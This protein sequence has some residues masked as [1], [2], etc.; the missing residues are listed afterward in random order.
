MAFITNRPKRKNTPQRHRRF[1]PVT[2]LP[3]VMLMLGLMVMSP[4]IEAW[5]ANDPFTPPCQLEQDRLFATG[6]PIQ[7]ASI[8]QGQYDPIDDA[9]SIRQ[10][11]WSPDGTLL[12]AR[13]PNSNE[14]NEAVLMT[15]DGEVRHVFDEDV[16]S[17][18]LWSDDSQSIEFSGGLASYHINTETWETESWVVPR[19]GF[20]LFYNNKSKSPNGRYAPYAIQHQDGTVSWY[21][22][23]L[24]DDAERSLWS[25]GISVSDSR[26]VGWSANS[27]FLYLAVGQILMQYDIGSHQLRDV[28]ELPYVPGGVAISPDNTKIMIYNTEHSAVLIAINT[29]DMTTF[30]NNTSGY[31]LGWTADSRYWVYGELRNKS[32]YD[33][34]HVYDTVENSSRRLNIPAGIDRFKIELSPSGRYLKYLSTTATESLLPSNYAVYDLET[35]S[36]HAI[37]AYSFNHRLQLFTHEGKDYLLIQKQ[38]SADQSQPYL[39]TL[40]DAENLSVCKIGYTSWTVEFQPQG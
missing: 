18:P 1:L 2:I 3:I 22:K 35:D 17:I 40:M 12:T 15:A 8:N 6:H 13:N 24:D 29:L 7:L 34:I 9:G 28:L 25:E 33:S 5:L 21:V 32:E 36:E 14:E 27:Q 4:Q 31:K 10:I 11:S 26:I 19:S 30:G 37:G 23:D 16:Y 39:T 20:R 38:V